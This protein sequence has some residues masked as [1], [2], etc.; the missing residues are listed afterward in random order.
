MTNG[1]QLYSYSVQLIEV[2]CI[3][4]HLM[5][6]KISAN[7]VGVFLILQVCMLTLD[8]DDADSA[9]VEDETIYD[10]T[11]ETLYQEGTGKVITTIMGLQQHC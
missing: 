8:H 3:N 5:Y 6:L 9:E 1:C 7:P 11:Y 2:Q 10:E 4:D